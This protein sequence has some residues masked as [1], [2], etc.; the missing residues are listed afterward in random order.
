[1]ILSSPDTIR[2]YR[3]AGWWGDDTLLD[4][5]TRNVAAHPERTAL[6]DPPNRADLTAGTPR[7]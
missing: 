2:R 1:M 5:W 3:D 4:L 6:V 7:R